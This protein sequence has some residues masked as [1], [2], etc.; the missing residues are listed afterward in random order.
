MK[1]VVVLIKINLPHF[2][3]SPYNI[4]KRK[5]IDLIVYIINYLYMAMPLPCLEGFKIFCVGIATYLRSSI[6]KNNMSTHPLKKKKKFFWQDTILW[7]NVLN[8]RWLWWYINN[9]NHCLIDNLFHELYC[10]LGIF[11]VDW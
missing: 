2:S 7:Y 6:S 11:T 8:L 3:F 5:L 10:R 1:I 4:Y 9:C